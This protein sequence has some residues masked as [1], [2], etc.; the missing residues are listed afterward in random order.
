MDLVTNLA[1]GFESCVLAFSGGLMIESLNRKGIS[2]F[3]IPTDYP[4]DFRIW[5]KVVHHIKNENVDII[6]AHGTRALSNVYWAAKKLNIPLLYTVHGW[7]IHENNGPLKKVIRILGERFLTRQSTEVLN[8]SDSNQET[9]RK[10]IPNFKSIVIKNGVDLQKFDRNL[11]F[12]DLRTDFGIPKDS[13]LIGFIA[14]MTKQ[15]DP[16]TMVEGFYHASKSKNNLT[17]LMVGDGEL[18]KQ[19]KLRVD[20][21]GIREKVFFVGFRTDVSALL[22]I[23]DVFCLPSLWEGLP[24]G[25]L[26]AMAMGKA[27]I[28]TDVDGTKEIVNNNK[29]GI[30]IKPGDTIG[31]SDSILA[32]SNDSQL[33]LR[34]CNAAVQTIENEFEVSKMARQIE[35][36]YKNIASKYQINH[37]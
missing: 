16:I 22:N 18:V 27:V 3:I 36:V 8:V 12:P 19:T 17:L 1:P 20:D 35:T 33:R 2:N 11:A 31:L 30:L 9:G 21:L 10:Y 26:E 29:N 6:H 37:Q 24:I 13:I 34:L 25:L 14:R 7:S 23:I 4:F 15:K 32:I 28:A 5:G